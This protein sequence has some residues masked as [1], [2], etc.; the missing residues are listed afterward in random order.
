MPVLIADSTRAQLGTMF[1][2]RDF[3]PIRL[4]GFAAAAR[5]AIFGESGVL[6]RL[7]HCAPKRYP[8]SA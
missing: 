8:L 5:L 1:E 7:R 3:G 4:K 2:V 6:S